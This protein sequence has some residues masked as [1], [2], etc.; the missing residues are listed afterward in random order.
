MQKQKSYDHYDSSH[1]LLL[2]G[3]SEV[4]K[5]SLVNLL[6]TG[7]YNE[8]YSSTKKIEFKIKSIRTQDEKNVLKLLIWDSPSKSHYIDLQ[9]E[10]FYQNSVGC[11]IV[12]SL[13]DAESFFN[14]QKWLNEIRTHD[15]TQ[16]E[17][18]IVGNKCDDKKE[19]QITYDEA[20]NFA[21]SNGLNYIETSSK[22]G[23]NVEN[24]FRLVAGDMLSMVKSQ[25]GKMVPTSPNNSEPE[26]SKL[27][28]GKNIFK[29]ALFVLAITFLYNTFFS[30]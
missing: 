21:D 2:I 11:I 10:N 26:S 12:F 30:G 1:K 13:T 14:I 3:D 18:L 7:E 5:S 29:M 20:K 19:I 23:Y 27:S 8:F 4:G 25:S 17:I 22:T 28:S 9:K 15:P 6:V 16:T 24:A